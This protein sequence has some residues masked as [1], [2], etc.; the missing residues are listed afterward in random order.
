MEFAGRAIAHLAAD[1]D[2][3]KK[4]GKILFVGDLA[5]EYGFTDI[6]GQVRDFRCMK[7]ILNKYGYTTLAMFVPEFVRI[8]LTVLHYASMKF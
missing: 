7:Q 3:I 2:S 5:H 6:D 8:P 4:T 1:D